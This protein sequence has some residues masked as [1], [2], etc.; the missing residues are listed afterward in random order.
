MRKTVLYIGMSLDGFIA[1]QNGGV[2][3]MVGDGSQPDHPGT[4]DSFIKTIDTIVMGGQ[5]YRQ[6]RTELSP[7]V[8]PYEGFQTYVWT[9][10]NAAIMEGVEFLGDDLLSWLELEKRQAGKNIWI[11]GGAR[12]AQEVLRAGQLDKLH[13][14]ILPCLLGQ[15]IRLF[16]KIPAQRLQLEYSLSYN[17]MTDLVY[18]IL[19][20]DE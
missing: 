1:N 9:R 11:C 8:W 10:R 20:K 17:G 13:I 14:T 19:E 6:L 15:G 12:L 16:D 3:W 18:H 4:Y 7:D 2:N 5:T